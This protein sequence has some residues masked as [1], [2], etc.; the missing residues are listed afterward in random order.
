MG[1]LR[2]TASRVK[3]DSGIGLEYSV[4]SLSMREN[5]MEFQKRR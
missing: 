4:L 5:G 2:L 3:K 1:V